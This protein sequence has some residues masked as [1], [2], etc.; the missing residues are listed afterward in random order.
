MAESLN[1]YAFDASKPHNKGAKLDPNRYSYTYDTKTNKL[2]ITLPD[3]LACVVSYQYSFVL[4]ESDPTVTNAASLQGLGVKTDDKGLKVS[5]TNTGAGV[6]RQEMYVYKVD[7]DNNKILLNGVTFK[8]E[9]Y[10][11]SASDKWVGVTPRTH[12]LTTDASGQLF[13][14]KRD[15]GLETGT[16]YRLTE[17]DVGDANK[18]KGYQLSSTPYYFMWV[19]VGNESKSDHDIYMASSASDSNLESQIQFV[20]SSGTMFV[21]NEMKA[22]TVHKVWLNADNKDLND[23][24]KTAKVTL[25]RKYT[26]SGTTIDER[27][28]DADG[29][30]YPEETLTSDSNWSHT[31]VDLPAQDEAGN[32]YYYYVKEEAVAGFTTTAVNNDGIEKGTITVTNKSDHLV[33]YTSFAFNKQWIGTDGTVKSDWQ[34]DITVILTGK[35]SGGEKIASRFVI[36]KNGDGSFTAEESPVTGEAEISSYA[37]VTGSGEGT[38]NFEFQNLPYADSSGNEYSYLLTEVKVDGYRTEY[39]DSAGNGLAD[40][41][42]GSVTGRPLK[43]LRKALSC[44][45]PAGPEPLLIVREGPCWRQVSCSSLS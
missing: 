27:A 2:T 13:F 30:T 17:V 26:H 40:Q 22:I 39:A 41:D 5:T 6:V 45:L 37:L 32:K 20:R 42:A 34:K 19:P 12:S 29:N 16:L 10:D 11:S 4:G 36:T 35:S 21:P 38:F 3:A 15:D 18:D 9:K 25:W 1:V 24:S 7:A 33:Q 23:P 14:S 31:W 28:K 43:M 44:R 8:L